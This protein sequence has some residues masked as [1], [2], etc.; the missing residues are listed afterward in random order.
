M[1]ATKGNKEYVIDGAQV[2][3]YQSSGF[4]V[5]DDEG[6]VIAYGKG[7]TVPYESYMA[8]VKEKENLQERIRKLEKEKKAL[9]EKTDNAKE[10]KKESE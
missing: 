10:N 2:K 8:I 4:D 9:Q 1:K 7:K 6:N 5:K 3:S